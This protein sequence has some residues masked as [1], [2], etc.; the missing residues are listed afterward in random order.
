[1]N[2]FT[3]LAAR[4]YRMVADDDELRNRFWEVKS[5]PVPDQML[6]RWL[7]LNGLAVIALIGLVL[8]L[9]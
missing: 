2:V 6:N 8:L 4:L 7:L 1:M 9:W 3:R 5:V